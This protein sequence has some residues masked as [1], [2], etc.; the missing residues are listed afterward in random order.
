[1]YAMNGFASLGLLS[2]FFMHGLTLE[3]TE[4]R[5]QQFEERR[6]TWRY[7]KAGGSSWSGGAASV[8]S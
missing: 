2:S 7:E 4:R 6:A 5:Q 1:M 3:K 8:L